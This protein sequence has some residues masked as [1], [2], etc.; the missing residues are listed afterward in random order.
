LAALLELAGGEGSG[1]AGVTVAQAQ[2]GGGEHGCDTHGEALAA[3][4]NML[5]SAASA[6][7]SHQL[8]ACAMPTESHFTPDAPSCLRTGSVATFLQSDS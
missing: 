7:F 6:A 4:A 8:S 3:A 2:T 5:P 1:A